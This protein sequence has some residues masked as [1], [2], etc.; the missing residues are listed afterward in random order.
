MSNESALP[1]ETIRILVVDDHPMMRQGLRSVIE[2]QPD[3]V[4]V[5]EAGDGTRA[6]AEYRR[7]APDIV[8]MDLQMDGM[9]GLDAIRAIRIDAPAAAIV[10]LTSYAGDARITTALTSGAT[11]YLLKAAGAA[12]IVRVIRDAVAG[13]RVLSADAAQQVARHAGFEKLTHRELAV[14]RLVARGKTNRTIAL[15][16]S[17]SEET[18]KSRMRNILGKLDACDRTHA[19]TL[20]RERGFLDP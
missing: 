17:V 19:V 1:P 10:V 7:L 4:V 14:L 11:S 18:V 9:D 6:I 16:L 15:L 8:L 20:A 5:G 13:Q 2:H 12:E 3:M